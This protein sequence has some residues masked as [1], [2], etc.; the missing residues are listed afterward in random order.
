MIRD[1]GGGL[2][3][4]PTA[5][6]RKSEACRPAYRRMYLPSDRDR[7]ETGKVLTAYCTIARLERHRTQNIVA[8][9]AA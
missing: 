2:I 6:G 7:N 3:V 4:T 5:T 8:E 1:A 9:S